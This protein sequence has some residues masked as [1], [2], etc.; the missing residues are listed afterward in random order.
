[1]GKYRPVMPETKNLRA[2]EASM[3]AELTTKFAIELTQAVPYLGVLF[4]YSSIQESTAVPASAALS[5]EAWSKITGIDRGE[6][7]DKRAITVRQYESGVLEKAADLTA[8]TSLLFDYGQAVD[9]TIRGL[10]SDRTELDEHILPY[11]LTEIAP[12]MRDARNARKE[13]LKE[14]LPKNLR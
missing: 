10:R 5:E 7:Y 12:F 3:L 11:V 8:P 4:G 14:S 13:K 1:M 9:L 6:Y 2:G